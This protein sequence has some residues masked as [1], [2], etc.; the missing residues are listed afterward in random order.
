MP[1]ALETDEIGGIVEQFRNA[2]KLAVDAGF[3]GVEVHAANGYLL[4]QFLRDKTNLRKDEYGGPATNRAR[5]TVEVAQ[6]VAEVWGP[7]RIGVRLSPLSTFND[8]ADSRA[9]E[10][11]SIAGEALARLGLA[12]IHV[13]EP[14]TE[15]A[16]GSIT[17]ALRQRTSGALIANGGHTASSANSYIARGIAEAVSFGVPFIA[18]PDLVERLAAG[19]R[20]NAPD[21]STFYTGGL[22]G[23]VDYPRMEVAA[24]ES[25]LALALA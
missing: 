24:A 21:P 5:L 15:T 19:V 23:Y 13:I 7:G 17:A 11:F 14:V 4:D 12:Y 25:A 6:A 8:I 22:R 10:T 16:T 2:A 3:D 1:R 18:N 20:L 9:E